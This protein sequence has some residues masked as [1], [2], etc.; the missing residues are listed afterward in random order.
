MDSRK[1]MLAQFDTFRREADASG[2]IEGMDAFSRRAF[3][4][5]TSEQVQK[6]FD[7]NQEPE[8]L[9][10][11]YGRNSFGAQS[12]LLA[13]RLV[14]A[15]ARFV[16]VRID[17]QW[18]SHKD[19]FTAHR[20][21]IPPFD[22][23]VS[24]LIEDLDQRG[25]LDTTLVMIG[26]EFG[27]TP[28]INKD[29]GRDHWPTVYTTVLAGGGLKQGVIVGESDALAET[30]KERP[31]SNQDVLATIYHQ[32]GIDY[33]KTYQNEA[34]RPVEILNHGKPIAEIL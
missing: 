33:K 21:L 23:C 17:G 10:E 18:D 32:L 11:R 3:E 16:T 26:G 13:R 34:N 28:K 6:A 19:N 5:A 9:R 4:M 22:Q 27:R 29:A 31:I 8:E 14:E 2:A 24:A 7:L 20:N 1:K 30:P 25:L 12:T 15:G